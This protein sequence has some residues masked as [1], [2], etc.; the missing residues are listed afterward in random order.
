M[1]SLILDEIVELMGNIWEDEY[2][3]KKSFVIN[4]EDSDKEAHQETKLKI[5]EHI[6]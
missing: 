1:E 6:F 5:A 2:A 3:M 4:D